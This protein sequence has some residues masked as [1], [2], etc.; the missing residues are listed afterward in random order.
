VKYLRA[1]WRFLTAPEF[2][3]WWSGYFLA[4]LMW[5]VGSYPQSARDGWALAHVAI[6]A[7]AFVYCTY[8]GIRHLLRRRA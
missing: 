7:I 5:L 6:I 8:R 4:R 3:L 2:D 1:L